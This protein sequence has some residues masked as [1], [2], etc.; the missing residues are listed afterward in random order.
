MNKKGQIVSLIV[1]IILVLILLVAG[2]IIYKNFHT[3][4][5]LNNLK[6]FSMNMTNCKR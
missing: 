3:T 4:C 6:S 5:I 1:I 2:Y